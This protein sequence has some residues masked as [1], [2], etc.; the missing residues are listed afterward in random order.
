MRQRGKKANTAMQSNDHST[1]G[2]IRAGNRKTGNSEIKSPLP[3]RQ[4]DARYQTSDIR[5]LLSDIF[6]GYLLAASDRLARYVLN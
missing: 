1:L 2:A 5:H 4:S 6:F 3:E